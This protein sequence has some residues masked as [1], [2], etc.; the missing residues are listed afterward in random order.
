MQL[1]TRKLPSPVFGPVESPPDPPT[2]DQDDLEMIDAS[3]DPP[4]HQGERIS[5]PSISE[6]YREGGIPALSQNASG[7]QG[8]SQ[9]LPL[10]HRACEPATHD[11]PFPAAV[12]EGQYMADL[13]DV[14][15][16]WDGNDHAMA[17]ELPLDADELFPTVEEMDDLDLALT[18]S[19]FQFVADF[20]AGCPNTFEEI[21]EYVQSLAAADAQNA[22]NIQNG[23]IDPAL[24]T[25]VDAPPDRFFI[26]TPSDEGKDDGESP[27]KAL[28]ADVMLTKEIVE[29]P[30]AP[31]TESAPLTQ[32]AIEDPTKVRIPEMTSTLTASSES[33]QMPEEAPGPEEV[34]LDELFAGDN[35]LG[36]LF[37][38]L[39]AAN[40]P[41]SEWPELDAVFDPTST[42]ESDDESTEGSC[43][44]EMKGA[45]QVEVDNIVTKFFEHVDA[46]LYDNLGSLP[47][48]KA[49]KSIL[50]GLEEFDM[51]G[52]MNSQMDGPGEDP[53]EQDVRRLIRDILAAQ[54]AGQSS[55]QSSVGRQL[56]SLPANVRQ[57][58]MNRLAQSHR[59]TE[60]VDAE[61]VQSLSAPPPVRPAPPPVSPPPAPPLDPAQLQS[62]TDDERRTL[63]LWLRLAPENTMT[64]NTELSSALQQSQDQHLLATAATRLGIPIA[65]GPGPAP[66]PAP[67]VPPSA[68]VQQA[69]RDQELRAAARLGTHI[70][71]A[72][73]PA[74]P[75]SA[76]V[77]QALRDPQLRAAAQAGTRI[78]PRSAPAVTTTAPEGGNATAPSNPQASRRRRG[79]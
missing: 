53:E 66:V 64:V 2:H 26:R 39:A 34:S 57:A 50:D 32:E 23:T 43:D 11:A 27:Q 76:T 17:G 77:Q 51:Y 58:L 22:E 79:Q 29:G 24:L 20:E 4:K 14:G 62:L 10:N 40:R 9:I 72:P 69:L 42:A 75:H 41:T 31:I 3:G 38:E 16:D 28:R 18:P 55:G 56:R 71:P 78:A 61:L 13:D 67:V 15:L 30:D 45:E 54:R 63:T 59:L 65:P 48:T 1:R 70:A 21:E 47:D 60:N 8:Q 25:S 6:W 74:A 73:V 33:I 44:T 52:A 68:A 19:F 36:M 46:G 7:L 5:L 49:I 37:P 12:S 35:E